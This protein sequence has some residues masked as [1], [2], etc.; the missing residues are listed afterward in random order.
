MKEAANAAN[1][2]PEPLTIM[3]AIMSAEMERK[4]MATAN[5]VKEGVVGGKGLATYERTFNPTRY[6]AQLP[7]G[8]AEAKSGRKMVKQL[9]TEQVRT[10]HP[11]A[12]A[13]TILAMETA[14]NA[15]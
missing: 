9:S 1:A 6:R 13:S 5:W 3:N 8:A 10:C 11:S 2:P 4:P 7:R 14:M 15:W 12:R